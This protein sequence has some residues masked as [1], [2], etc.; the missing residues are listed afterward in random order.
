MKSGPRKPK[1]EAKSAAAGAAGKP[2]GQGDGQSHL[3]EQP[4][5]RRRLSYATT[6]TNP[7]Q[8]KVIQT[9]E[10]LLARQHLLRRI[11]R[12]ERMGVPHGQAFWAQALAIMGIEV[13]TPAEETNRVPRD[14]PVVI[15]ANHPHGLVDGMVL[16]ELIG[17][18]RQDYKILTRSLLTG[19]AEIDEFMIPVP[20]DHEPDAL[21]K[22]LEMRRRAMMHLSGG[23][24]IVLF[25]SGSVASADRWWG[26]AVEKEWRVFTAKLILRSGASV[27]PVRFTGQNSRPYQIASLISPTIRQGLLLYEVRKSL[28]TA[29]RPIIGEPIPHET[30]TARGRDPR[31]FMAWLRERT[32][33]LEA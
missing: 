1:V 17:R 18:V 19:V 26:P 27:V 13:H 25:P 2:V 8:Q 7:M 14:G 30:L 20:F 9:M 33:T 21:E 32:L 12:F 5:D 22:S 24:L 3:S 6:F 23:G 11:R 31:R 28:D 29:Q 10:L 15:T 4:Y 16:A